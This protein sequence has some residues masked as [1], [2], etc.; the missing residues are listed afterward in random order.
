M[1]DTPFLTA[2]YDI[3]Q[4]PMT[5]L[6]CAAHP[7]SAAQF[8]CDGCAELLCSACIEESHRLLLC[9][10]CGERALPLEEGA[11]A[12]A[13]RR[14]EQVAAAAKA[15]YGIREAL[16]Y[17]LRG[18]GLLMFLVA[19]A[20]QA[21]VSVV[22][23]LNRYSFSIRGQAMGISLAVA[24][25]ALLVGIQFRIV[26]TTALGD[27]EMP[28]WPEYLSFGERLAE[29]SAYLGIALL[30]WGPLLLVVLLRGRAALAADAGTAFWIAAAAALWLGTALAVMA[31]GAAGVHWRRKALRVDQHVRALLATG[32]D[33]LRTV[34][35]TFLLFALVVLARAGLGGRVAFAGI[36]LAGALGIYW[37]FLAPHLAGVLFRR[38]AR[39][40][41]AI[42]GG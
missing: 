41:D 22:T 25:L 8:R 36:A 33:G 38:H 40:L 6:A 17:P 9:R 29:I 3:S 14:R 10:R 34:N 27:D 30:Q 20:V 7:E 15:S 13:P 37:T 24:W 11:A 26:E 12:T 1:C 5:T 31:W 2:I 19:L 35:V 16:L 23:F 42:Y 18:G 32:G 4:S 21:F 39:A 28:D